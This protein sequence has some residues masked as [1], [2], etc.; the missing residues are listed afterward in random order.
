SVHANSEPVRAV[1]DGERRASLDHENRGDRP[2]IGD[3][4]LPSAH[5]LAK[6]RFPN[7]LRCEA[8]TDV[9]VAVAIVHFRIERIE[10]TKI[11]IVTGA[12]E[13]VAQLIQAVGVSVVRIES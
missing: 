7:R 8:V 10:V 2:A 11:E 3:L 13:R 9:H 4:L 1:I 5:M 12:A 6:W